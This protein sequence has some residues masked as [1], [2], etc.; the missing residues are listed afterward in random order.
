VTL[1]RA[2]VLG[3]E[4][5]D[6]VASRLTDPE[7]IRRAKILPFRF[8]QAWQQIRESDSRYQ[9][10]LNRQRYNAFFGRFGRRTAVPEAA[11]DGWLLDALEQAV[12]ASVACMPDLPGR[13]AV[14]LDISGS[15]QGQ[16]LAAGSV[17]ALSLLKKTGGRG[18]FMLFDTECED[19]R[20]EADEPILRAASRICARGGT[21]TGVCLRHLIAQN[22]RCDTIIIVT[23]EQQNAGSPFYK[24][25]RDYRYKVN[26]DARAFVVD[27]SPYGSAM[28]P[29]SDGKTWYC[30]GWSDQ[31]VSFIAQA[32]QGY[33]D[34][35]SRVSAIELGGESGAAC[36]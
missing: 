2:G 25:L 29:P 17:L 23:D 8:A 32:V 31:V 36:A 1:Q 15:M 22:D 6:F 3:E 21:D 28:T 7:A 11:P 27:V 20:V 24:R 18:R 12:D 19:V 26:K 10:Y 5:N 13:T 9:A 33:G 16:Y 35:V 4:K 34:L 30:F 14:M